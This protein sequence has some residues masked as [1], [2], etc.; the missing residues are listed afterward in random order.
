MPYQGMI[1]PGESQE[2]AAQEVDIN[3]MLSATK[4]KAIRQEKG[5]SQM[6]LGKAVGNE[7]AGM[8]D[9]QLAGATVA[10]RLADHGVTLIQE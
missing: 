6:G 4:L 2:M 5:L 10:V 8:L 3:P 7:D 9:S 1:G